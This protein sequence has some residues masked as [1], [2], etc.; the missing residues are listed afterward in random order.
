MALAGFQADGLFADDGLT[1]PPGQTTATGG[2]GR[3]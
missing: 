3:G 2:D 1:T